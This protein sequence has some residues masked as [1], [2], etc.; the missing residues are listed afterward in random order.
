MP[1]ISIADL[2]AALRRRWW[3]VLVVSLPVVLLAQRYAES[4]P[5]EY[6]SFAVVSLTLE[7]DA[8]VSSDLI[9]LEVQRYAATLASPASTASIA[10]ELFLDPEL[11]EDSVEVTT[12]PDTGNIRIGV[13]GASPD[14]PARIAN[15]LAARGEALAL[16]DP[17][18]RA[19][20]SA[21]AVP[22]REPSGP[23]RD[24][25]VA[26][27]LF[28]AV[29]TGAAVVMVLERFRPVVHSTGTLARHCAHRVLGR[30]A[31]ARPG[32]LPGRDRDSVDAAVR[33]VRG[34]LP[35][36]PSYAVTVVGATADAGTDR[37]VAGL[38]GRTDGRAGED[39]VVDRPSSTSSGPASDGSTAA[40][41]Q[42]LVARDGTHVDS[43]VARTALAAA[44]GAV[45]LVRRGTTLRVLQHAID[46]LE[47]RRT[48]VLG[49]WLTT[50]SAREVHIRRRDELRLSSPQASAPLPSAVPGSPG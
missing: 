26:V 47:E 44:D 35:L 31:L 22:A 32:G 24:M 9:R 5:D 40:R 46:V 15:R 27:G 17:I 39:R 42:Q 8:D 2:L 41:R 4:L 37:L 1:S 11:L 13:S 18:L 50:P 30:A 14:L 25:V 20:I 45:L 21:P 23:A 34:L 38:L 28:L 48:P 3:L 12:P 29:L 33:R 7:P 43:D 36:Q 16:D 49:V 10:A 6:E 19:L